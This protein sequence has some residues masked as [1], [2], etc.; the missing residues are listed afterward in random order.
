MRGFG[1]AEKKNRFRD[2]GRIGLE[3]D[4]LAHPS[5]LAARPEPVDKKNENT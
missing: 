4:C 5:G 1:N 2:S 3:A